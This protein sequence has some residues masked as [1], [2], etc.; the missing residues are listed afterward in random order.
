MQA[1][2]E[3]FDA[4]T[5]ILALRTSTAPPGLAALT[6]PNLVVQAVRE[7]GGRGWVRKMALLIRLPRLLPSIWSA[8]R[9][10][11][12]VHTPVP[13]DLGFL[14]LVAA[15][16]LR[17]R[18]FV[19]HC[20]TW[21]HRE[22]LA[23]RLLMW[24]LPRIAGARTI[25]MATGG[26]PAPPS[27]PSG[28][29]QWIFSTTLRADDFE[30]LPQRPAWRRGQALRLVSATRLDAAKNVEASLRA[31]PLIRARYPLASLEIAGAG[32]ARLAL[33]ALAAELKVE[34]EVTFLG[35]LS[36]REVLQLLQRGHIFLFPTRVAE[37]FPK[38]V[39]EALACGLAVVATAVSV[40]P[41]LIGNQRGI[42]LER[43]D[44][45]AVAE[46][47]LE[48]IRDEERLAAMGRSGRALALEFSLERWQQKIAE[49]LTASW[50]ALRQ[51][52]GSRVLMAPRQG[53]A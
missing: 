43:P 36:H 25:V 10:A 11:D 5:L 12:A 29:I 18:L 50:G 1:I 32:P 26:G 51:D 19:R 38:A 49:R 33:E 13:G 52:G 44:G 34:R 27:G 46:A 14:A 2:A 15:L 41:H 45:A 35:N 30:R 28:K 24:L 8:M 3:L 40:V 22:T 47:V 9:R 4:T 53:I 37:G 39:L 23:D 7:P 42:V 6:G 16:V 17:K 48:L 21:G 31:L 20:G